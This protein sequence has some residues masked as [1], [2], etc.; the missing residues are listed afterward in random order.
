MAASFTLFFSWWLALEDITYF[1]VIGIFICFV[2][3]VTVGFQDEDINDDSGSHSMAGDIVALT[4][5]AGYGVYTTLMRYKVPNDEAVSMQLLLGY[6]GL[7]TVVALSPVVIFLMIYSP[8]TS[9]INGKV[10]GFIVLS[11]ESPIIAT[12]YNDS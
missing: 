9:V 1:K 12:D 7:I 6:I 5:S 3:A 2:G 8:Q 10:F 4:S 11:G